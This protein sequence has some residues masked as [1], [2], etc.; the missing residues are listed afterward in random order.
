MTATITALSTAKREGR[1][2]VADRLRL[3]D[4]PLH[5]ER[6]RIRKPPPCLF[7]L[8]PFVICICY[9]IP[10]DPYAGKEGTVVDFRW[11]RRLGKVIFDI[12]FE[13]DGVTK[14]YC[15]KDFD[16]VFGLPALHN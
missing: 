1:V 15:N 10:K 6:V 9:F 3:D 11:D 5:Y 2:P 4:H 12:W 13:K 16:P 14:L 7:H 8:P